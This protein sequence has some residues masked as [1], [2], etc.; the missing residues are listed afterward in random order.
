[1]TY[2]LL[3]IVSLHSALAD[4]RTLSEGEARAFEAIFGTRDMKK[5]QEIER[6]PVAYW[7]EREKALKDKVIPHLEFCK[8]YTQ[9]A[10]AYIRDK[11]ANTPETDKPWFCQDPNV[12][13]DTLKLK[14]PESSP[15]YPTALAYYTALACDYCD[16][17][18]NPRDSDA[19]FIKSPKDFLQDLDT[20]FLKIDGLSEELNARM[21]WVIEGLS[22]FPIFDSLVL[23]SKKQYLCGA[24]EY[25]K[26]M[27]FVAHLRDPKPPSYYGFSGPIP[28]DCLSHARKQYLLEYHLGRYGISYQGY[29][30]KCWN[31]E[32]LIKNNIIVL[33]QRAL[34]CFMHF[35]EAPS[36]QDSW[37]KD[38]VSSLIFPHTPA[39]TDAGFNEIVPYFATHATRHNWRK[40][41]IRP[42][43][44]GVHKTLCHFQETYCGQEGRKILEEH[45]RRIT[46]G[47]S[48]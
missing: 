8:R 29:F 47:V 19:L 34:G 32:K 36:L 21:F 43:T 48:L 27:D 7:E 14:I 33:A 37:Q 30:D 38:D 40:T 41:P 12:I 24:T 1:M 46:E 2:A 39:L 26:R 13:A 31:K 16:Y 20:F 9:E 11:T 4:L 6:D 10:Q 3:L 15:A 44:C 25:D 28:H 42:K 35:H 18:E 5:L 22:N 23:F 45:S 17:L